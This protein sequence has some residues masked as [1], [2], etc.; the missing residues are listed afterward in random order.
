M[1]HILIHTIAAF[2]LTIA[3]GAFFGQP[4]IG[5]AAATAFYYSREV[6]QHQMW[7]IYDGGMKH[8]N[9]IKRGWLLTEWRSHK[10]RAEFMAPAIVSLV[11]ATLMGL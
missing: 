5:A 10:A 7:L 2:I 6:S 9:A 1:K 4:F 3:G 11:L 8:A